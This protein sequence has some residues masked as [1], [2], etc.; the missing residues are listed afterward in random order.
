MRCYC[1][2]CKTGSERK[3]VKLLSK[4]LSV[5]YES[6][7]I[8]MF[9]VRLIH[10]KRKGS[11][12]TVEQPLLPGYLFLYLEDSEVIAP[13]LVKQERDVFKILRYTD[14]SMQL[15]GGDEEYALWVFQHKGRLKPSKVVLK[16]GLIIKVLEGPLADMKGRV[17]KLDKHHKRAVVAFMFAGAERTMNLSVE[18]LTPEEALMQ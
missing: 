9:P 12:D 1:I 5:I 6:E 4:I 15:R 2:Y 14:G 8:L 3:L 7:P 11:W 16:E 17:V 18:V 10:Q 13:S